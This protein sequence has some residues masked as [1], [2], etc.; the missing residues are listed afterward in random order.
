LAN[1]HG[2][3]FWS[4][5]PATEGSVLKRMKTGTVYVLR[6]RGRVAAS[7]CLTSKKPWAIDPKYFSKVKKP[8]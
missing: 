6:Q 7:L 8:L 1:K 3:G 2:P 5:F 4:A